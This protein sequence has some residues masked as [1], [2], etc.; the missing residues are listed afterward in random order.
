MRLDF[1]L[2][3]P[4]DRFDHAHDGEVGGQGCGSGGGGVTR[5]HGLATTLRAN[6]GERRSFR[7]W[8]DAL[9]TISVGV[10][11]M[12]K[13]SFNHLKIKTNLVTCCSYTEREARC[14]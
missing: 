4:L 8:D 13:T 2:L 10:D 14:S 3:I 6:N 11:D 9:Q 1:L 12:E 7:E 5:E